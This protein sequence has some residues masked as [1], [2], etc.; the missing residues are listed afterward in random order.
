M[1]LVEIGWGGVDW[2]GLT[3]DRDKWRA[4]L[5]SVIN[6]RVHDL[7]V[8]AF[9]CPVFVGLVDMFN[10]S[11]SVLV[12]QEYF[13]MNMYVCKELTTHLHLVPR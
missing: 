3:Q 1:D 2:I 11:Y 13:E 4:L 12:L 5:N 7:Y 8:N 9:E 6:L 10:V